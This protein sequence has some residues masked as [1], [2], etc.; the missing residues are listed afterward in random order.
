MRTFEKKAALLSVTGHAVLLLAIFLL[1]FSRP[2]PRGYPRVLT[3][4]FVE[5]SSAATEPRSAAAPRAVINPR[6]EPAVTKEVPSKIAVPRK[7]EPRKPATKPEETP[8]PQTP[9]KAPTISREPSTSSGAAPASGGQEGPVVSGVAKLDVPDF[10]FPH[11]IA[12]LQLRIESHWRPPYGGSGQF[13]A[14]VHFVIAKSGR[15]ISSELEKSSG[16]FAFDQA[17]LRAVQTASPLPQLPEGSGLETL[18]VHFDFVAN[19]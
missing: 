5:R 8:K 7:T 13:L 1:G 4:T 10:A 11:Y 6:P 3:A 19:W 18:G 9:A 15:V 2:A 17:A 16:N 12:L 14:T